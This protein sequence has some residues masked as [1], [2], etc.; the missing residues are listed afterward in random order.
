MNEFFLEN[1]NPVRFLL[2][3]RN[4]D[5][6]PTFLRQNTERFFFFFFRTVLDMQRRRAVPLS[7]LLVST[8]LL[9]VHFGI[10]H[11]RASLYFFSLEILSFELTVFRGN[12]KKQE[13]SSWKKGL[14][15]RKK[16]ANDAKKGGDSK[17][18]GNTI[19]KSDHISGMRI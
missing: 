11:S 6:I 2:I 4:R 9:A 16:A 5:E 13:E 3:R 12:E 7:S 1:G 18:H 10:F 14:N 15:E 8:N 19:S 17:R